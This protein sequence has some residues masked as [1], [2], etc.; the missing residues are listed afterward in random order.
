[1]IEVPVEVPVEKIVEV[2]VIVEK[3]IEAPVE[4]PVEKIVY[5]DKPV[6]INSTEQQ[7]QP[8]G[9]NLNLNSK[10][11]LGYWNIRGLGAPI[12]YLLHYIG[13]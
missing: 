2:P 13:V 3:I 6:Y 9:H 8:S 5:V 4:V 7:Q 1:V 10:P 11:I 12:R